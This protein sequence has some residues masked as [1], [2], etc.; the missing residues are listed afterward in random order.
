MIDLPIGTR[1]YLDDKLVEV[2]ENI[3]AEGDFCADCVFKFDN[4]VCCEMFE[5]SKYFR[6][7]KTYVCFKEVK[8]DKN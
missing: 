5:C 3:D 4:D 6:K 7:D 8:N 2:V 1:F